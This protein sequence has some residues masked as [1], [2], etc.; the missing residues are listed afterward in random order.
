M[1]DLKVRPTY[2]APRP[3]R[4]IDAALFGASNSRAVE[5]TK[6]LMRKDL[7]I[8][9]VGARLRPHA[10]QVNGEGALGTA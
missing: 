1:A 7:S 10:G 4:R 3:E 6:K 9:I 8:P 2:E 5:V